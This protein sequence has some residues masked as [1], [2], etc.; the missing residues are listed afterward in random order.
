ALAF[1]S[2]LYQ[3]VFELSTTRISIRLYGGALLISQNVSSMLLLYF[4]PSLLLCDSVTASDAPHTIYAS[5][6]RMP[7]RLVTSRWASAS[8]QIFSG[9]PY[10]RRDE[11]RRE[12]PI[13]FLLLIFSAE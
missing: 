13:L 12:T 7:S 10:V 6:S 3:I 1:P 8:R 5:D 2:Q 4:P 9:P 11:T